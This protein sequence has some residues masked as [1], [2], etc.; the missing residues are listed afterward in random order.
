METITATLAVITGFALR[1][2]IPIAITAIAITFL[3]RLDIRWQAEAEEQLLLPVVKKVK[4]WEINNCTA[5]MRAA[6]AGYQS[7][8]PCWQALREENGY[9]Q[10]RCL[11]CDVFKQAPVPVNI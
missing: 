9:L 7:E 2:A 6:C 1:L 8:Q 3:K 5:E 10:D 4:C 11:G